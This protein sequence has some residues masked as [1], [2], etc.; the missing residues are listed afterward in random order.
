MEEQMVSVGREWGARIRTRRGDFLLGLLT[1][2][3]VWPRIGERTGRRW[4]AVMVW[5]EGTYFSGYAPEW[6]TFVQEYQALGPQVLVAGGLALS[7]WGLRAWPSRPG[8][9]PN[10]PRGYWLFCANSLFATR[11]QQEEPRASG[12]LRFCMPIATMAA[13]KESTRRWQSLDK[14]LLFLR[15]TPRMVRELA[16]NLAKV[17][18]ETQKGFTWPPFQPQ[19]LLNNGGF[20]EDFG[21]LSDPE[22]FHRW[23]GY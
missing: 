15:K 20:E 5:G 16:A 12:G 13:L 10:R 17:L 21:N 8:S 11:P 22:A 1:P 2:S 23:R 18:L 7:G 14:T 3:L 9:W 4:S 19:E 6:E